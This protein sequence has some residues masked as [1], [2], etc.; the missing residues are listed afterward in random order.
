M[1]ERRRPV[2]DIRLEYTARIRAL[3]GDRNLESKA[4]APADVRNVK[5][6]CMLM[7]AVYTCGRV[8]DLSCRKDPQV[9]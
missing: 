5:A 9:I 1:V 7:I 4:Q 2:G 3:G 8:C 6:Y